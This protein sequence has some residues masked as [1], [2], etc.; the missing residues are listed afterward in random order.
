[1]QACLPFRPQLR[2]V[3]GDRFVGLGIQAFISAVAYASVCS[4][5]GI[6]TDENSRTWLASD[7]SPT[8]SSKL[9]ARVLES[10]R[11]HQPFVRAWDF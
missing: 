8:Y 2:A 4:S 10:W 7:S 11:F 6:S 9:A 1:M 3:F 5:P